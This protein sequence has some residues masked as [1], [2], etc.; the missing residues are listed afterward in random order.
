MF[1]AGNCVRKLQAQVGQR[2]QRLK[3]ID[4]GDLMGILKNA[5]RGC[6]SAF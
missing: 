2:P 1:P 3:Q 4:E 5:F 6:L